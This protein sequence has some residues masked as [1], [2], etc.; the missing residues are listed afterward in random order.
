MGLRVRQK[1]FVRISTERAFV[2]RASS[3]GHRWGSP[4]NPPVSDPSMAH[5]P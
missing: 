2:V 3:S 1:G 4:T 5:L